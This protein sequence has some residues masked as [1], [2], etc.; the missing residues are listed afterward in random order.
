MGIRL[1]LSNGEQ[2]LMWRAL[3][4]DVTSVGRNPECDICIPHIAAVQFILTRRDH[5]L[6]L[7]NKAHDGTLVN[8]ELVREG[9]RL[10][11]GDCIVLGPLRATVR[12]ELADSAG[13][14]AT[15]TLVQGGGDPSVVYRVSAEVPGKKVC[16]IDTAGVAIGSDPSNA[17]VL[18]D[19]YVSSFHARLYMHQGRCF[20]QDLDSRNGV[21]VAGQRVK[22]A[23]VSAEATITVGQTSLRVSSNA[24]A[25]KLEGAQRSG[26]VRFMGSSAAASQC[27]QLIE[28]M[29][30]VDAQVLLTG[31]TGTGKEVAARL[32]V[33]Y[34]PR[35]RQPL[36]TLNCGALGRHLI[37]S[38]LFGH[39][40]G[41][42]TGA[43]AQKKGAFEVADGGTLFLDEIGELPLDLQPQLLRAIEYGEIRRVG[44]A[45][46]FNV[47]VRLIAATHRVLAH[48]VRQGRFREDLFHRLHILAI[49]LPTLRERQGDIVELAEYFLRTLAP[50]G[51]DLTLTPSAQAALQRHPWPGNVRELR[52]VIQRA[53]LMRRMECI[54]AADIVFTPSTLQS[55]VESTQAVGTRTLAEIERTEI[56]KQLA[57]FGG[58]K[59][60]AAAALGVSRSTIHRKVDEYAIDLS[61][62]TSP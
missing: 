23:E 36:V 34:G 42:F 1:E 55:Y 53:V 22:E 61:T 31:E 52:N 19:P 26:P 51:I 57:R 60:E 11:Q 27:R 16:V 14:S 4:R 2:T 20:L 29:A 62:L 43:V 6:T 32:L 5:V 46:T 28:R 48:E 45:E 33:A 12:F 47:N 30:Q 8:D 49:N 18:E 41:A 7:T 58:N 3:E 35:A 50:E 56:L 40:K 9:V 13:G 54:D 15:K 21:Y 25:A 17:I 24:A 44:S 37:E 39:E 38:E 10:A 59:T